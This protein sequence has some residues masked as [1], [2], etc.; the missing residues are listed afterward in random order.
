MPM[1][2]QTYRSGG[3]YY[4]EHR[5]SRGH[6]LCPASGG[7]I[8]CDVADEQIG[9]LVEA[10]ELGP[11]WEEEVLSIISTKDEVESIAERRRKVHERLRRLGRA[12]VDGVYDDDE[13]RRQKRKLEMELESLIAPEADAASEAGRLIARLPELWSGANEGERRKLLLSML[14]A[15]YMDAKDEKRIVAIKPKAPFRPVFQVVTTR[16]G[17]GVALVHDPEAKPQTA[18]QPPPDGQE[19]DGVS[20]SWWRRGRV[21]LHP[22][23]RI[24]VLMAA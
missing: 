8:R 3:R 18:D 4:R 12:Y 19:A 16:E 11:K 7:S 1:W 20:C 15:V 6:A 14:D 9:K 21:E 5:G 23:H 17:S 13:Y 2:A 10:I 22:E 24:S